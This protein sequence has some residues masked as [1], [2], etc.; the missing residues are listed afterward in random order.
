MLDS[1]TTAL[2][3]L[4]EQLTI[5][6]CNVAVLYLQTDKNPPEP[7]EKFVFNQ[8]NNVQSN[9]VYVK[10]LNELVTQMNFL[11]DRVGHMTQNTNILN[12]NI[13]SSPTML[14]KC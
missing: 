4:R 9:D 13:T 8:S 3:E 10:F 14:E 7:F 5:A 12:T 2:K 11:N 1:S 6:I